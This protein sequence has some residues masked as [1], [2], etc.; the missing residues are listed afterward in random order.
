[1]IY[2]FLGDDFTPQTQTVDGWREGRESILYPQTVSNIKELSKLYTWRKIG[3]DLMGSER[4][5]VSLPEELNKR[6]ER[7]IEKHYRAYITGRGLKAEI[8][9]E[10]LKEWLDKR[11]G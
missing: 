11:G 9:E 4:V 5:T 3:G 8:I 7:Y 10:A 1:V 2:C 6:L